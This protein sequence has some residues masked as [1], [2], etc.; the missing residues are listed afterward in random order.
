[1]FLFPDARSSLEPGVFRYYA[2]RSVYVDWKAGGQVNFFRAFADEWWDR[3]Q[4]TMAGAYRPDRVR[5]YRTRGI[6]YLVFR[7]GPRNTQ[8]PQPLPGPVVYENSDYVAVAL[9]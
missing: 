4:A 1:M 7:R 2:Q 8:L 9:K 6:Q 5:E 3:W